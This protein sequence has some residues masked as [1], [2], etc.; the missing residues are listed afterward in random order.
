MFLIV[1]NSFNQLVFCPNTTWN[2]TGV[3][4]VD[5]TIVG[6]NPYGVFVTKNNTVYFASVQYNRVLMW[7]QGNSTPTTMSLGSN[8]APFSIFVTING[9][10]YIGTAGITVDKWA[11]NNNSSNNPVHLNVNGQCWDLFIDNNDSLYC[12]LG[13]NNQIVKRSLNAS[14]N[15]IVVVAGTGSAGSLANQL[16]SPMGI[17]VD[18]NF[19]LYVADYKNNRIQQFLLGQM[20]GI[21]VVGSGAAGTIPLSLPSYVMMDALGNLFIV[22]GGNNRIVRSGP[23]GNQCI[24]GCSMVAGIASNQLN[25]P[26]S[27][28]F[29]IYGNIYVSDSGNDRLQMFSLATNSCKQQE[30]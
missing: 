20:N 12:T 17:F 11:S 3:T 5:N 30:I 18:I 10:I 25:A 21:T 23:D 16:D 26:D 2:D 28:A 27:M 19:T 14:D 9:D 4:M 7:I 6:S 13:Q 1:A 15:N 24:I 8:S 29:D 22:D